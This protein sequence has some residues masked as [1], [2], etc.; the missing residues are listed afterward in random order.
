MW[1]L[2]ALTLHL[3]AMTYEV[4]WISKKILSDDFATELYKG[5][6]VIWSFRL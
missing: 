3:A 2:N 5:Q 1:A 4:I 6:K